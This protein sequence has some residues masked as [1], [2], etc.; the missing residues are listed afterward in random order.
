MEL[1]TGEPLALDFVNTLTSEFDALDDP[2]A[3]LGVQ[4]ERLVPPSRPLTGPDLAAVRSLR[5]H[6]RAAID[7]VRRGATPSRADI[8]ALNR[9]V[10]AA[11]AY[12]VL[13]V[14]LR[15]VTQRDGDERARLLA[16]L[17]E[18]AVDLLADP[19]A[20]RIRACEGPQCRMLFLSTHPKRR[21]CSPALCGNRVRVAR[22]YQRHKA[23]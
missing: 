5:D 13:D 14:D 20:S 19:N 9:A 10:R 21:W 3:W 1:F 8:G 6:V 22:Y 4:A 2:N 7:A 23:N 17:A 15:V 12:Q 18:A 16:Q 11:P